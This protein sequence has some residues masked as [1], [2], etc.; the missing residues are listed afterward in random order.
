MISHVSWGYV[1]CGAVV[2]RIRQ[3]V[4]LRWLSV[5]RNSLSVSSILS[6]AVESECGTIEQLIGMLLETKFLVS[7]EETEMNRQSSDTSI[8]VEQILRYQRAACPQAV[9]E[10]MRARRFW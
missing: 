3:V 10:V 6:K 9:S 8:V 4:L 1:C 2:Y 7:D 5:Q